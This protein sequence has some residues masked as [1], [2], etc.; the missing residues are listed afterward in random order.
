MTEPRFSD[1]LVQHRAR[2][3]L[4]TKLAANTRDPGMAELA[5]ELL[6]GNVTPR[7]IVASQL[8]ADVLEGKAEAFTSWYGGLSDEEREAAAARGEEAQRELATPPPTEDSPAEDEDFSD[9]TWLR[10]PEG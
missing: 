7:R 8:Y 10:G 6:A 9:R 1:D 5:R 4:L 3:E 2:K